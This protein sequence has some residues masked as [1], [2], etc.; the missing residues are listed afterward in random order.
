MSEP[1][2][3]QKLLQQLG[4]GKR[5]ARRLVRDGKVRVDGDVVTRYA[6]LVG[7]EQ[8][9]A[10]DE[11]PLAVGALA[12]GAPRAVLLM[13]KPVK[14]VTALD[15]EGELPGLGRYLPEDAPRV[16]PVGRLDVNTTGALLLTNDGELAR[17]VL[18]PDWALPKRYEVKIRDH[19]PPEHPALERMRAGMTVGGERYRPV[20]VRWLTYRTRATWIELV[21]H[22][23]K[24]RQIRHM[25]RACRFQI[26]K[27]RRVA[28]G[29]LELGD[30]NPRCVRP[31]TERE[32]DALERAV[33][34]RASGDG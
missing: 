23:G 21:L 5:E 1:L 29:P 13:H 7:P 17:R 18:H 11:G 34:L 16:F 30:L 27:L 20:E 3:L 10:V 6:E 25:C 28:I 33:G 26:V 31:L 9:L 22:E 8:T 32:L 4:L 15:D 12:A 24:N 19:L 14:H 2:P